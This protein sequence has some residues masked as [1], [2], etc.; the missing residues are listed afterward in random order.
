[1]EQSMNNPVGCP[2]VY[3]E[4]YC[5]RLIDHMSEGG[6]YLSF[7]ATLDRPVCTATLYNW[8][9]KYPEFLE[10][11]RQGYNLLLRWDESR[12][13]KM[14]DGESKGNVTALIFKMKNCHRWTDRAE[15]DQTNTNIQINL[16]PEDVKV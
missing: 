11:K 3:K 8:E 12:L 10:A 5:Q 15:V 14:I 2:T 7:P 6:T 4:E 13:N 9:K 1:M 16:D